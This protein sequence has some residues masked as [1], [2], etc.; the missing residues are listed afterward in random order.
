MLKYLKGT[1][2]HGIV[3]GRVNRSS[4]QLLGY[5]DSDF[6]GDLDKRRSITKYVYT[7]C[8]G[9]VS[10][11][12]SLQ[13]VVALSINEVEYIALSEVVKEAIWLKGLVTEL[14]LEQ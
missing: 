14:G 11:K 2:G 3:Y 9:A 6:A 1:V 10:W 8:G 4:D 12:A 13:L 5:I 7:L